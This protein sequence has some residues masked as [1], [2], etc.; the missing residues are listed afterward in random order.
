MTF[1][2]L[3]EKCNYYRDL[4]D[5]RLVPNSYVLVMLDGH[6]FSQ[7]IKKRFKLPFDDTF[8]KLV[9]DTACYVAK[10]VQSV[11]FGY[12]QSDEMSFVLS[13]FSEDEGAKDSFFSYRLE[14]LCS[15]ISGFATSYFNREMDKLF[16]REMGLV[17]PVGEEVLKMLDTKTLFEF[18]CK[19]WNVPSKN[20]VFAW[21]LYR[22]NDC[23][24]NSK[25]AV[26]QT[27]LPK[28]S[29]HGLTCDEQLKRVLDEKGIDWN[30]FS[31]DKKYGRFIYKETEDKIATY[32]GKNVQYQRTVWK[33]HDAFPLN[34]SNEE[35]N[36]ED[37]AKSSIKEKFWSICQVPTLQ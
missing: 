20:E 35:K 23:I 17:S 22:Q 1:K 8:I 9:N 19:A 21:M 14:K 24:R 12:V 25:E 30:D 27:Y 33:A 26:A 3:K 36:T 2:N 4:S 31:D 18:D 6:S 7:K 29:L 15:I 10:Q 32:N 16:I 37:E 11:K 13:D 5:V 34:G 28:K